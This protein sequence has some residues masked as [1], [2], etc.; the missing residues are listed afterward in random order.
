MSDI[1]TPMTEQ[2]AQRA[3]NAIKD[4]QKSVDRS[5]GEIREYLLDLDERAGYVVLGYKSF[6]Q[7]FQSEFDGSSYLYK[8]LSHAR[9]EKAVWENSRMRE[10]SYTPARF[11][12][13]HWNLWLPCRTKPTS[14]Q[15]GLRLRIKLKKRG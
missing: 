6:N 9:N 12:D 2:E 10:L 14:K 5:I 1:T 13:A 11:P 3:V 7:L 15:H 4:R 8:I